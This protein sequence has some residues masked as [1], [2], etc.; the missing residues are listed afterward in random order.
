[1]HLSGFAAF[2]PRVIYINVVE[3][4]ELMALQAEVARYFASEWGIADRAGKGRA[5]VPHMTVAFRDLS[6]SNFHAGWTE[7]KD[8]AFETQFK[9]AALTLLYHNGQRWEI[10]QEF[11]LG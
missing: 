9:V 4:A 2:A 1:M 5:F 10:C 7:F 6:K 3:T 8:Q 11:P